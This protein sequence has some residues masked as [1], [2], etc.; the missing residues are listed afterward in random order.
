MRSDDSREERE[1]REQPASEG[2][3]DG[4]KSA[5]MGHVAAT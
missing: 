4:D 5:I 3:S 2:I 1:E